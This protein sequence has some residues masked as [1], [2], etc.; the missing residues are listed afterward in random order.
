MSKG[1]PR[2]YEDDDGRVLCDMNVPGMPWYDRERKKALKEARR[3]ER[4]ADFTPGERM[5]RSEARRYTCYALLAALCVVGIFSAAGV[6]FI[7]FC[8][9]VWF[10]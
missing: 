7:L 1:K 8:T 3:Q 10:R 9:K 5:T 6:L 2:Q 4:G